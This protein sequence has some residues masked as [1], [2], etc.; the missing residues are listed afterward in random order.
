MQNIPDWINQRVDP[1]CHILRLV[2]TCDVQCYIKHTIDCVEN[3]TQSGAF[4]TNFEVFSFSCVC[5]V[6]DHEFHQN[7]VKVAVDP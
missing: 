1:Y 5:P 3:K 2:A 4:L 7:I 6:I